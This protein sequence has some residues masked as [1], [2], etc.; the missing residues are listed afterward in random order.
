MNNLRRRIA[1]LEDILGSQSGIQIIRINGGLPDEDDH[2][3]VGSLRLQRE[4]RESRAAFEYRVID[5]AIEAGQ[6]F[7]VFGGLPDSDHQA[8]LAVSPRAHV[9]PIRGHPGTRRDGVD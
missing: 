8:R 6:P 2:V 5:A 7:V 1:R 4:P 3:S 9:N